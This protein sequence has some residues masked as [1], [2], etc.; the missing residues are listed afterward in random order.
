MIAKAE[1]LESQ[2]K[3]ETSVNINLPFEPIEKSVGRIITDAFTRLIFAL[4]F[5][6]LS[7]G[8]TVLLFRWITG[9]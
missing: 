9:I 3:S 5:I 4:P 2:A 1:Q 6:G 7:A 8:V